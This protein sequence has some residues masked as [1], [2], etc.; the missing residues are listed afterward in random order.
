MPVNRRMERQHEGYKGIPSAVKRDQSPGS[1]HDAGEAGRRAECRRQAPGA[2]HSVRA[3]VG[4]RKARSRQ[5]RGGKQAHL[6]ELGL[7]EGHVG[8]AAKAV[9]FGVTHTFWH[10][11]RWRSY[12]CVSASMPP[13]RRLSNGDIHV[14]QLV[15]H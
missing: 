10:R 1:W 12:N 8:V 14:T 5:V 15:P 11:P 2:A 9:T 13:S 3:R 4:H 7:G 6:W